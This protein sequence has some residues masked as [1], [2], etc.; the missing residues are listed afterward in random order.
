MPMILPKHL[1]A[2]AGEEV[3]HSQR[4]T[5]LILAEMAAAGGSIT[6]A[7]YMELALYA[8]GLG[9]Y[10]AGAAKF[11]A[12]GDFVTAPEISPLFSRCLARQCA[13]IIDNMIGANILEFGAGSG[14]MAAEL[15]LELERR[16]W[17]PVR[18]FI[19]EVSADLR[20]R[21]YAQ[22]AKQ[23]PHLL[24]RVQWL[25]T[26]PPEFT[27]VIIANEVLDAMPVH[28]LR[29]TSENVSE[30]HV[31]YADERF[32]WRE[33]PLTQADKNLLEQVASVRPLIQSSLEGR[34]YITEI[35]I[36]APLWVKT[37]AS[38]LKQGAILIIDYGFPQREYYHPQRY[39]GTLMCHYRHHAHTDPLVLPG[40]Q[41]ITAHVNFT[42][43]AEAAV[44]SG[45]EVAGYAN[46]ANFLMGAGLLD[47]IA[48][49]DP[50]AIAAHLELMRQVKL[51]TLPSEMGELFK[52]MALTRNFATALL[53]FSL[54]QRQRL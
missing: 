3:T 34:A 27:G 37:L 31:A 22:I 2:P 39:M 13:Q 52:V 30:M 51:L 28:C 36:A 46:Q 32:V 42:A 41:D 6:F 8:P 11:G 54:D 38:V 10:A 19:L 1:P 12:A 4:V 23:A 24:D 48:D 25:N 17:L 16:R 20:E 15:L 47:M 21:Q 53:G 29:F 49:S 33:A 35:N 5:D 44:E 50:Q 7:R 26:L 9:Y 45:L 40:L 18:Y 14:V 43:L